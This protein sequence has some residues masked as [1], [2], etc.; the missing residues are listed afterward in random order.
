MKEQLTFTSDLQ[1]LNIADNIVDTITSQNNLKSDI[2]GNILL[3]LT[4]AINNAI[5][6]GNKFSS[7]K[8]VTVTYEIEDEN[9]LIISV[10]DEGN[11]FDPDTI[12]DPTDPENIEKLNGRGVF[13]IK[14]LADEVDYLSDGKIV[15]MKFNLS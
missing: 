4:E 11:G 1:N 13:L 9:F 12:A 3:S 5:V 7:S 2:Y 6:H 14:N 15:Q 8:Q 10:Q